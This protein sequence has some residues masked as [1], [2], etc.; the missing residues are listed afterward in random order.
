MALKMAAGLAQELGEA[1]DRR[2]AWGMTLSSGLVLP[3]KV[4]KVDRVALSDSRG[5]PIG[6]YTGPSDPPVSPRNPTWEPNTQV[7]GL[8]A[9]TPLPTW[10]TL[11]SLCTDVR[12]LARALHAARRLCLLDPPSSSSARPPIP[13]PSITP[14]RLQPTQPPRLGRR[15]LPQLPLFVLLLLNLGVQGRDALFALLQHGLLPGK[16]QGSHHAFCII[17]P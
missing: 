3:G 2:E 12:E 4:C 5:I 15:P 8:W 17:S 11:A 6:P 1:V 16:R 10:L 9:E 7:E 13:I 14:P